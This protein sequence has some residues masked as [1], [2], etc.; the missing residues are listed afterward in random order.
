MPE[1]RPARRLTLAAG[2]ALRCPCGRLIA[3]LE[4]RGVVLKCPRCKR[5]AVIDLDRL[6][7]GGNVDIYFSG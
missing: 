3:R 5:E 7:E 6:R 2:A 1:P 4:A